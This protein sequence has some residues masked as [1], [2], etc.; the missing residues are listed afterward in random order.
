M[1]ETVIP[2][3][4]LV[5]LLLLQSC[6]WNVLTN[7]FSTALPPPPVSTDDIS[8]N[9]FNLAPNPGP[10]VI[11]L[12][13]P[14]PPGVAMPPPPGTP[15]SLFALSMNDKMRRW[16]LFLF[17]NCA[18]VLCRFWPPYVPLHGSYG[19]SYATS[20]GHEASRPGPLSFPGPSADGR[21]CQSPRRLL[22][23]RSY[24]AVLMCIGEKKTDFWNLFIS[25]TF[26]ELVEPVVVFQL[27]EINI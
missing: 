24:L 26:Y 2:K 22:D 5:S 8:A 25:L 27:L 16:F 9:Y 3:S 17:F 23:C 11:N 12:G 13:I 4:V 10:A 15:S 7:L 14:P 20:N 19:S 6:L 21:P 1:A 18:L